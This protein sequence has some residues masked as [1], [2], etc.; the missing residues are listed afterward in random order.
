VKV[1]V[2]A[3]LVPGPDAPQ[4][5]D[6]FTHNL[7]RTGE[8]VLDDADTYGVEVALRLA[9]QAG[10][11]EVTLVT[12]A[13][14][15]AGGAATGLRTALAMGASRALVASDEALAGS[16][17]LGTAKVL[18]ALVKRTGAD[19]VVAA[20]ESTDGYTG[21]VPVQLAELLGLPALTYA[22][23]VEASGELLKV[24]RQT[25]LGSEEV[26][27]PLPAVVT[28]TAGV[29]EVRYPSLKGIM[30]AKGKPV[31]VLSLLELGV[32]P[33]E[34]GKPGARQEVVSTEKAEVRAGGR[35]LTDDGQAH[36]EILAQLAAWGL[37]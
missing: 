32:A 12:V 15:D 26:T 3:K 35:V 21:T 14:V 2:C 8:L 9:E 17:A 29:V 1:A 20:T 13:P 11:G 16:D 4:G 31:E 33:E 34:V 28:V 23:R 7:L 27:C 37:F 25:D 10:E 5:F 6:P 24:T 22:N 18:A 36:E 30:A 19:L